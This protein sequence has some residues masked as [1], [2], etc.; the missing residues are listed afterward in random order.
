MADNKIKSKYVYEERSALDHY[1]ADAFVVR[2][3]DNRFWKVIKHFIKDRNMKHIDTESP[4]GGAKVFSS[5]EAAGDLDYMFR[6]LDKSVK[7]HH[8]KTVMLFSHHDC[9]AYGGFLRFDNNSDK[10]LDFH[11]FEHHRGA[12]SI[13][14]RF[15]NLKV[16]T[17]F[18]D[19]E[20]I[21]KTN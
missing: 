2:C 15:P 13:R 7:L 4:A 3:F 8:T 5:P 12:Q 10:E 21:I 16:E 20:G 17:Y 14:E 1:T 18:V 19:D 11:R 9:G 6:E